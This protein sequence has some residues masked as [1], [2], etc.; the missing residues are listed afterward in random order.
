MSPQRKSPRRRKPTERA[1]AAESAPA[2]PGIS[3]K[4][5]IIIVKE[6]KKGTSKK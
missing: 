6:G 4:D 5:V 2:I 1:A 3:D